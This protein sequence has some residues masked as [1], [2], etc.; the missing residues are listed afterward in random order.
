MVHAAFGGGNVFVV[1][2]VGGFRFDEQG[3]ET[4]IFRQA[5]AYFVLQFLNVFLSVAFARGDLSGSLF[6]LAVH[7]FKAGFIGAE[8][9]LERMKRFLGTPVGFLGL[10]DSKVRDLEGLQQRI[11][12]RDQFLG[13]RWGKIINVSEQCSLSRATMLVMGY[14]VEFDKAEIVLGVN[15]LKFVRKA[16]ARISEAD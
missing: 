5:Q 13:H 14:S 12:F 4:L 10:V 7:G 15:A 11:T 1:G 8:L 2:V 16:T 6:I 9:H 3:L